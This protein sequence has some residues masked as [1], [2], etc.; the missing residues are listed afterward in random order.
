[1]VGLDTLDPARVVPTN[2]ADMVAV[3]L[4]DRGLTS[5]DPGN[6]QAVPAL[7]TKWVS[8]AP[9][10]HHD[11]A[12]TTAA[13]VHR[14]RGHGTTARLAGDGG[15]DLDLHHRSPGPLRRRLGGHARPTSS[16]R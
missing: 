6:N 9:K 15:H 7:A 10:P 13:R 12:P 3:N 4:L 1:M 8:N 11:R 14:H 16:P 2:L 5:I